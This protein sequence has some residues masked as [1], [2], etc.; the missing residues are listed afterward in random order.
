MGIVGDE[1]I[2]VRVDAVQVESVAFVGL[3]DRRAGIFTPPDHLLLKVDLRAIPVLERDPDAPRDDVTAAAHPVRPFVADPD[4]VVEAPWTVGRDV[5]AGAGRI[6]GSVL[7]AHQV[8]RRFACRRL[9]QKA[10][11]APTELRRAVRQA[12][13][14]PH[15]VEGDHRIVRARLDRDVPT[16]LRG[17]ELIA[18]EFRQVDERRRSP[19]CEAV[20]VGSVLDEQPGAE[21]ERDGEPPR[22]EA[23]RG[24][25][26]RPFDRQVLSQLARSLAGRHARRG[27]APASQHRLE[28]VAAFGQAIKRR[29][30]AVRLLGRGD[31][32]LMRAKERLAELRLRLA[33]L[34]SRRATGSP[35]RRSPGRRSPRPK[36]RAGSAPPPFRRTGSSLRQDERV[37]LVLDKVK[38]IAGRRQGDAEQVAAARRLLRL[39]R[40]DPP[41][42]DLLAPDRIDLD[43]LA[44]LRV[45]HQEMPVGR[46]GHGERSLQQAVLGDGSAEPRAMIA[47]CRVPDC[48]DAVAGRVRDIE[49][50][51]G[52]EGEPRRSDHEH[53]L[54]RLRAEA[55]AD[56]GL[57]HHRRRPAV[58]DRKVDAQD[59]LLVH[60]PRIAVGRA[61]AESGVADENRGG[62]AV[63]D[64]RHVAPGHVDVLV[65]D[66]AR[67]LAVGVEHDQTAGPFGPGG[68]VGARRAADDHPARLEHGHRRRETNSARTSREVARQRGEG[69]EL[70]GRRI[71]GDDGCPEPLQVAV[72]V[73]VGD[74]D[75]ALRD[76]ARG[77]RSDHDCVR[78]LVAVLRHRAGERR[79]AMNAV[80][81]CARRGDGVSAGRKRRGERAR[82]DGA[83]PPRPHLGRQVRHGRRS[84]ISSAAALNDSIGNCA[85]VEAEGSPP[86]SWSAS[87]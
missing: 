54:A 14:L 34:A 81:E 28:F 65:G 61:D 78:I 66:Y 23:E 32:A 82:A 5:A 3:A 46:P 29:E 33:R 27:A 64:R 37:I 6:A 38:P 75:V 85:R 47:S 45:D 44:V 73:E 84:F 35:R 10:G 13:Q 17:V 15:G 67:H 41:R 43:D 49:R 22:R 58:L 7:E 56:H 16:R 50:A 48:G 1:G 25:A 76:D 71:E 69:R 87:G 36:D 53:V 4:D 31:S 80:E 42:L 72:V 20:T 79:L 63:V 55:A 83:P 59:R 21:A 2:A 19:G 18:V 9:R 77:D 8:P 30:I 51:V 12:G 68:A 57:P 26:V 11:L 74:E 40:V 60:H 39:V 52:A 86:A 70:L 24:P 62:V